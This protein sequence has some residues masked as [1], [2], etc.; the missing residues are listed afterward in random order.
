[1]LLCVQVSFLSRGYQAVVVSGWTKLWTC[2]RWFWFSWRASAIRARSMSVRGRCS[3][4]MVA[5]A[6]LGSAGIAYVEVLL[7]DLLPRGL[8]IGWWEGK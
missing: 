8:P 6:G 1:V 2:P 5:E 3:G 7:T 4:S